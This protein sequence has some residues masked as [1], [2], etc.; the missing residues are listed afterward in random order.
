MKEPFPLTEGPHTH[1]TV[2][3]SFEHKFEADSK[4]QY[5][6]NDIINK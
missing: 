3:G 5:K 2:D 1:Q 6:M 4:I